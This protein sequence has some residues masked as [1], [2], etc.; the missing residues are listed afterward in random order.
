MP[1]RFRRCRRLECGKSQGVW[2]TG[3]PSITKGAAPLLPGMRHA[4]QAP[5]FAAFVAAPGRRSRVVVL[6]DLEDFHLSCAPRQGLPIRFGSSSHMVS[7]ES[8]PS[9][10]HL[11]VRCQGQGAYTYMKRTRPPPQRRAARRLAVTVGQRDL[12]HA[13]KSPLTASHFSLPVARSLARTRPRRRRRVRRRRLGMRRIPRSLL[14]S[15][16]TGLV[17]GPIQQDGDGDRV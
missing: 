5:G 17:M 12:H 6:T 15:V 13:A 9:H 8:T 16:P 3:P 10:G 7:I 14:G 4:S 2:G 11:D 1:R